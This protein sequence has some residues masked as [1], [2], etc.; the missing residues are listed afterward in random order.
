MNLAFDPGFSGVAEFGQLDPYSEQPAGARGRDR[1]N[2]DR[3]G[4]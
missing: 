3:D 2:R 4:A 1:E